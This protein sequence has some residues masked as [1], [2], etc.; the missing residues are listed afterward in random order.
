MCPQQ[1]NYCGWTNSN[2]LR[3]QKWTVF[4]ELNSKYS[5]STKGVAVEWVFGTQN[6]KSTNTLQI[7]GLAQGSFH[8]L[9]SLETHLASF[10]TSWPDAYSWEENR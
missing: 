10:L 6:K 5:S 8:H 1:N 9:L 4:N 3:K 2:L 7:P